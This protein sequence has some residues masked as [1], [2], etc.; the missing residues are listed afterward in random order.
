VLIDLANA[1]LLDAWFDLGIETHT[2][3]LVIRQVREARQ[4]RKVAPFVQARALRVRSLT[5]DELSEAQAEFGDLPIGLEDQTVLYIA[6]KLKAVLLTG[7][8]R[9]RVEGLARRLEVHGILWMLDQF[10]ER[11]VL[12]PKQAATK[13]KAIINAGAFLPKDTCR[14][15]LSLWE[16]KD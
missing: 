11:K 3:D 15:R 12:T 13:L 7:D 10:I 5:A 14:A 6:V 4:W 1:G 16:G 9:V 2:T 8:R